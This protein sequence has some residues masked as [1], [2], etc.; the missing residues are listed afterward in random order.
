MEEWDIVASEKKFFYER[1][2]TLEKKI[3]DIGQQVKAIFDVVSALSENLDIDRSEYQHN[4]TT[5]L[6]YLR[7]IKEMVSFSNGGN[8]GNGYNAYRGQWRHYM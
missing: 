8:G 2:D 7:E 6:S 5:Y 3:S 4:K 1:L